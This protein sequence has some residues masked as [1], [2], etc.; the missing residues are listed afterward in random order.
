MPRTIVLTLACPHNGGSRES[1]RI[2]ENGRTTGDLQ[3]DEMLGALV[4]VTVDDA[5]T[6]PLLQTLDE[7]MDRA[8]QRERGRPDPMH[9]RLREIVKAFDAS[10]FTGPT[11]TV[12]AA[13]VAAREQ[14]AKADDAEIPF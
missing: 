2:T 14:I 9:Q 3:W 4:R 10:G 8:V 7:H 12:Q 1:W 13:L 6:Y 5:P 11:E